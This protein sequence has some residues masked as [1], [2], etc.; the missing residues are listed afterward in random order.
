MSGP[1]LDLVTMKFLADI[2]D[3]VEKH[4][5]ALW[6]AHHETTEM[7]VGIGDTIYVYYEEGWEIGE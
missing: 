5:D 4:S 2:G 3:V 7:K 1:M 6:E